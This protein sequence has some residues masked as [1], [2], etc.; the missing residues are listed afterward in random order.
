MP[1]VIETFFA[2]WTLVPVLSGVQGDVQLPFCLIR[3]SL[4]TEGAQDCFLHL[5]V[6]IHL[7]VP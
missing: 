2:L 6:L 7:V 5:H 4:A 1:N 3:E